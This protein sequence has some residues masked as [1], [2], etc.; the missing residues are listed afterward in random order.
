V[1]KGREHSPRASTVPTVRPAH[2]PASGPTLALR[3]SAWLLT[4]LLCACGGPQVAPGAPLAAEPEDGFL[5]LAVDSGADIE[6]IEV[7]RNDENCVFAGP[8]LPPGGIVL[9]RLPAGDWCPE[10]VMF[11]NAGDYGTQVSLQHDLC[12]HVAAGAVAYPGHLN[13]TYHQRAERIVELV[14]PRVDVARA[15]LARDWPQAARL[16]WVTR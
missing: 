8:F 12:M 14:V 10:R 4:G 6:G 2:A 16:H 7:C 11:L 5:L 9:L 15:A 3:T 1:S 13:L